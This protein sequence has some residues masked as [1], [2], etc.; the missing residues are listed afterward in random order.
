MRP[1]GTTG[2]KKSEDAC[3]GLESRGTL[4]IPE[5][6]SGLPDGVRG[7][8]M[9]NAVQTITGTIVGVLNQMRRQ[10]FLLIKK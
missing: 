9:V 3:A 10:I 5:N 7:K 8:I 1:P 4:N 2:G 6:D